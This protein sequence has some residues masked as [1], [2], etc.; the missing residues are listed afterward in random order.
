[1]PN[2]WTNF[3]RSDD[4]AAASYFYLD[5]PKNN[6]PDLQSRGYSDLEIKIDF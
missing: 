6:L 1:M 2:A 3:Y 4:L 5:S